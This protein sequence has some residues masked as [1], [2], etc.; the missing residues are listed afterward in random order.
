[1]SDDPIWI[2]CICGRRIGTVPADT[3]DWSTPDYCNDCAARY[4]AAL[5]KA[6]QDPFSYALGLVTGEVF[7]FQEAT[8]NGEWVHLSGVDPEG[9]LLDRDR[10]R[11]DA[12]PLP[13]FI[14]G[15][16]VRTSAIAWCAD[17]PYGS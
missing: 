10:A 16:D 8:L 7:W 12:L 11:S 14:R 9:A 1:M 3:T 17:A 6:A 2:T 13:P 15:V 4:P 5:L